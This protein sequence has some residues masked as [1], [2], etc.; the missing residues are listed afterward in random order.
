M[1]SCRFDSTLHSADPDHFPDRGRHLVHEEYSAVSGLDAS[2]SDGD[3][4]SELA[5][6]SDADP[7][8]FV[9]DRHPVPVR[10][11]FL[12]GLCRFL[13]GVDGLPAAADW[14]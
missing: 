12:L 3:D 2:G 10:H 1:A 7:A 11:T 14:T 6:V 8:L 9:A 4:Q 13:D 5:A